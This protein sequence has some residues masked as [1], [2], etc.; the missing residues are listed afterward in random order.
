LESGKWFDD[1]AAVFRLVEIRGSL[2][3]S[4][5]WIIDTSLSEEECIKD[6]Q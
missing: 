2:Q 3:L 5:I 6:F 4:L 1:D